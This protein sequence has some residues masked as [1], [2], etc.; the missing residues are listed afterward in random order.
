MRS[1]VQYNEEEFAFVALIAQLN[2]RRVRS[3]PLANTVIFVPADGNAPAVALITTSVEF[4]VVAPLSPVNRQPMRVPTSAAVTLYVA[5]VP[6]TAPLRSQL[7]PGKNVNVGFTHVKV[8][9]GAYVPTTI[10]CVV[11]SNTV[12]SPFVGEV[13]VVV[14]P[15]VVVVVGV[16]VVGVVVV[17]VVVVGVVVAFVVVVVVAIVVVVAFVVVDGIV[18]TATSPTLTDPDAVSLSST[19]LA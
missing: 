19:P 3:V 14:A 7:Y 5:S 8:F 11:V 1:T 16:V 18:V 9:P 10:A 13:V 4:F 12:G 6:T 17:G 2:V 15:M